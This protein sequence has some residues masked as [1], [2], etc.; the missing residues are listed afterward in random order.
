MGY[1]NHF[2]W[3]ERFSLTELVSTTQ[4]YNVVIC[5]KVVSHQDWMLRCDHHALDGRYTAELEFTGENKP[6]YAT[7]SLLS[8]GIELKGDKGYIKE[9]L[10]INSDGFLQ[11]WARGVPTPDLVVMEFWR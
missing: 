8:V 6:A 7:L 9:G 5:S 3:D 2:A 1:S 10:A 11:C 4:E